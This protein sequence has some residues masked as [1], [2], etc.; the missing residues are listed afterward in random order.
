MERLPFSTVTNL[1]LELF[2]I[3]KLNALCKQ[4]GVALLIQ[5]LSLKHSF[6]MPFVIVLVLNWSYIH[7]FQ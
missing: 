2:G 6:D 1:F 4:I 3:I 7:V 5:T